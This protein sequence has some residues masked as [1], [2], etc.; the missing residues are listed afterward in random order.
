MLTIRS[1]VKV[2]PGPVTAEAVLP[3]GGPQVRNALVSSLGA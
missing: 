2:Y 3:Q 1:L